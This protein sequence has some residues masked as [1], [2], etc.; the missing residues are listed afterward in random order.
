MTLPCGR[1]SFARR[2]DTDEIALDVDVLDGAGRACCGPAL[3]VA[4]GP[5]FDLAIDGHQGGVPEP[6]SSNTAVQICAAIEQAGLLLYEEPLAYE[7][8][9]GAFWA[10]I[11]SDLE[12]GPD[13]ELRLTHYDVESALKEIERA[14]FPDEW[15]QASRDEATQ[16]FERIAR[17]RA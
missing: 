11:G 4:V 13:V 6:I 10:L 8:V 12:A 15:P 7:D 9:P 3:R 16:F 14:G 1:G 17:D 5:E 2:I